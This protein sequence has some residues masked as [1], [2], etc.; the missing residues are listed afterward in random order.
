MPGSSQILLL[1]KIREPLSGRV[2]L[3]EIW[4]LLMREIFIDTESTG[5]DPPLVDR[6]FYQDRLDFVFSD[7]P[8]VLMEESDARH[9]QAEDYLLK[10][11]GM[12]ALLPLS[13]EQRWKSLKDYVYT[14]LERDSGDLPRLYD[15]IPFRIFQGHCPS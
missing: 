13:E 12:P 2:S 7:L 11:G 15:L 6:L 8:E 3:Y 10:W 14:Y 9:G 4:P 1:K 5:A